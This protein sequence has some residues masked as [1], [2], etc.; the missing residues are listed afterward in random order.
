MNYK[1]AFTFQMNIEQYLKEHTVNCVSKLAQK[2]QRGS[3]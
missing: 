3:H 2:R 1:K